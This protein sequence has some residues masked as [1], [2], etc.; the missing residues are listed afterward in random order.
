MQMTPKHIVWSIIDSSSLYAAGVTRIQGV[1]FDAE[2][3][4]VFTSGL[5]TK[6]AVTPF[7]PQL[8]RIP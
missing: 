7:D 5:V 1:V 2:S 8:P 3:V 6:M 4:S